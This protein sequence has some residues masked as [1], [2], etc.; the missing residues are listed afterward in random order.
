MRGLDVF[1]PEP[2]G[3]EAPF[4]KVG[5]AAKVVCTPH[6]GASTDQ[7]AQAILNEVLNIITAYKENGKPPAKN[8]VN[9]RKGVKAP[10]NLVVRHF[11]RVGVL[12][13]VLQSLRDEGIN[14]EEMQNSIFD[15]NDAACCSLALDKKPSSRVIEDLSKNEHIIE[16]TF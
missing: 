2:A 15:G 6:I 16:V 4:D 10:V 13:M 1:D 12:A 9:L 8:V 7:A 5:L 3:G 11:N 14:I